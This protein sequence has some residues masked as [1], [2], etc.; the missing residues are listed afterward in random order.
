MQTLRD[1]VQTN[2]RLYRQL[3]D[4]GYGE[5]FVDRV[6]AAYE[7]AAD[8]HAAH[9]RPTGRPFI[10]HTVGTASILAALGAAPEVVLCGLLHGVYDHGDFGDGTRGIE[11]W[12]RAVMR[13]AV[14]S[15]V[16]ERVAAFCALPWTA[17]DPDRVRSLCDGPDAPD[18]D[19]LLVR[20]ANELEELL[21]LEVQFRSDAE[22]RMAALS[23]GAEAMGALARAIG[24]PDLA[25][26]LSAAARRCATE[27]LPVSLCRSVG[28]NHDRRPGSLARR[29]GVA[30]RAL[31]AR[32]RPIARRVGRR[33]TA[34]T[35]QSG[36]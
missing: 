31:L 26:A 12:K 6:R 17:G 15:G 24:Q 34:S 14:G 19:T 8:L 16:E 27:R 22:A 28:A 36:G 21:D 20:L 30:V 1:A 32:L 10:C 7:L 29:P 11:E 3:L 13:E 4:A 35:R 5:A 25:V 9:F 23:E 2:A 33:L 18:R